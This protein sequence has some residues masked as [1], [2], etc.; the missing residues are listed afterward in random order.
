MRLVYGVFARPHYKN[1]Y[2][3]VPFKKSILFFILLVS[4]NNQV[5]TPDG[6]DGPGCFNLSDLKSKTTHFFPFQLYNDINTCPDLA[7]L[8]GEEIPFNYGQAINFDNTGFFELVMDYK[9]ICDTVVFTLED[10]SR[11]PTEWGIPSWTPVPVTPDIINPCEII[12]IYPKRFVRG[13]GIPFVFYLYNN[14]VRA[15]GYSFGKHSLSRESFF[16]KHG[17]GS[18]V[19]PASSDDSIFN[20][21]VNGR[22]VSLKSSFVESASV[23]LEGEI[24]QN[25][26]I[27]KNEVVKIKHDLIIPSG[28]TL[29]INEGV[30][31]AVGESVNIVNYGTINMSG[32]QENPVFF[33]SSESGTFW[34]GFIST[35]NGSKIT[36]ENTIFCH[37]G[38]SNSG[39]YGNVGHAHQQALFYSED[40]ELHLNHCYIIDHKGQSFYS[41]NSKL[42]LESILVQRMISGGEVN[43]SQAIIRNSIFTDFPN[44]N[45][46]F[47][48]ADNDALYIHA[49][50]ADIDSSCFMYAKDDGLDSGGH[51]GGII[52]VSNSRFEACFHEGAALSSENDVLK[53]H[54]FLNC[55]FLNCGQGIELGYSSPNHKVTVDNCLF[56]NNGIGIRYGDNYDNSETN[57]LMFVK[58]SKS[59]HNII[60]VWNMVYKLWAPELNNM[61]FENVQISSFSRQYP[62]LE[63]TP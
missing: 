20:F 34:G 32:T 38:F 17:E 6:C 21:N 48:D 51:E 7:L 40:S 41:L 1:E 46:M 47:I 4:C 31:V 35:G 55:I 5:L 61:T 50:D 26:I 2:L 59:C 3:E 11:F 36:S 54:D 60:D 42:T 58:N 45:Q 14:G 28:Y 33:T 8:N 56:L 57:G 22:D 9:N 39:K 44:D 29:T 43:F 62:D 27:D 25:T 53:T 49:S 18:I 16:V 52:S 15:E 19:L 23:F 63:I 10:E 13:T 24:Q 30:I 37:S 12:P